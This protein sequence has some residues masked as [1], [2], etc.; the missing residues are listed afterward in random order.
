[1]KAKPDGHKLRYPKY[2]GGLGILLILG[3]FFACMITSCIYIVME[4]PKDAMFAIAIMILM[5]ALG[6]VMVATRELVYCKLY[7]KGIFQ[8]TLWKSCF[9]AWDDVEKVRYSYV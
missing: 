1:M 2:Y 7:A 5:G 3:T 4:H 6:V 8:R 9:I